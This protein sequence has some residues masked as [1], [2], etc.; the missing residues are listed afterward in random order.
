MWYKHLYSSQSHDRSPLK[1]FSQLFVFT[2]TSYFISPTLF[3]LLESTQSFIGLLA[4]QHASSVRYYLP[5]LKD[6][7][8]PPGKQMHLI[9]IKAQSLCLPLKFSRIHFGK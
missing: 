3:S 6:K 9:S 5:L 2:T 4:L 8:L 1:L 7:H